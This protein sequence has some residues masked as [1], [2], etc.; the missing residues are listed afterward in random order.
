M[1]KMQQLDKQVLVFNLKSSKY[2]REYFYPVIT[3]YLIRVKFSTIV[4]GQGVEKSMYFQ[5]M[6]NLPNQLIDTIGK[7]IDWLID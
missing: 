5:L 1:P 6:E 2:E 7:P 4:V 3:I